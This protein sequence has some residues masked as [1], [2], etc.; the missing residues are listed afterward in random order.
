MAYLSCAQLATEKQKNKKKLTM[1]TETARIPLGDEYDGVNA[2][3][4]FV[5]DFRLVI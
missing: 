2:E 4:R 3:G 5:S 1:E